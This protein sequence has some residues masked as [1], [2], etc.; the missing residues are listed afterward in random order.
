MLLLAVVIAERVQ[1][2]IV[3]HHGM[4][5]FDDRVPT[6]YHEIKYEY[7]KIEMKDNRV[8]QNYFQDFSIITN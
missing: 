3:E 8:F 5:V 7:E 2:E 4:L 6:S 1:R